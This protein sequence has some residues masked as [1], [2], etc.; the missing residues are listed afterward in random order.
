MSRTI[1]FANVKA[2]WSHG[3]LDSAAEIDG[4]RSD[5]RHASADNVLGAVNG[6][7]VNYS[8]RSPGAI[9]VERNV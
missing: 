5:F 7:N 6:S 8:G 3:S 2:L 9:S 4:L 1:S